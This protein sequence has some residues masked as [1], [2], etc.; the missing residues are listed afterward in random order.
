MSSGPRTWKSLEHEAPDGCEAGSLPAQQRVVE[1]R[2][3]QA[4]EDDL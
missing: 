4:I 3:G 1:Q 2:R